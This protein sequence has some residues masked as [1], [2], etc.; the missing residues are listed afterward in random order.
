MSIITGIVKE[1]C[2]PENISL[3]SEVTDCDSEAYDYTSQQQHHHLI[4]EPNVLKTKLTI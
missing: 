4:E 3:P 2:A 1:K